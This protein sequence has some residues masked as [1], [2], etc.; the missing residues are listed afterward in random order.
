MLYFLIFL[1]GFVQDIFW[2]LYIRRIAT[3]K[4]VASAFLSVI[5]L[6]IAGFI[7][8]NFV[9]HWLY[10]FPAAGGAFLATILTITWDRRTR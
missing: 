3:S 9:A 7:T 6:F 8:I 5:N 10:L 1:A 4:P 2:T